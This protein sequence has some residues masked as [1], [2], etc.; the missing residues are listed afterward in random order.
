MNPVY[1]I[2]I[3]NDQHFY[4]QRK[5]QN[6]CSRNILSIYIERNLFK[7]QGTTVT[8][9]NDKLPAP[10]SD[11]AQ[12]TLKNPYLFDLLILEKNVHKRELEKGLMAHLEKF[13]LKL[14]EGF[15]WL[16]RQY[17]LQIEDQ[18][19]YISL[20]FYRIKLQYFVVI[21]LKSGK[22][23]PEYSGKMN[24]YLSAVDDLV[25]QATTLQLALFYTIQ[26]LALSL[27]IPCVI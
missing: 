15:I 23:K 8:N 7:C 2:S 1:T 21:K 11:L 4:I 16:G 19:F 18:D 17:Q 12:N 10:E 20:L 5:L 24:F 14:G 13:F 9:F 6:S 26:K 25:N 27:N 3:K 22:F